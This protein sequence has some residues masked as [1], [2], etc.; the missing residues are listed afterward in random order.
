MLTVS[1]ASYESPI[2]WL[3]VSA[4]ERGVQG[5]RFTEH[6]G[7]PAGVGNEHLSCCLEQLAAYFA[8]K[9]HAF[10]RFSLAML[11]TEFQQRVWD[12]ALEIPFGR[13][14]TYAE[15]AEQLGGRKYARAVARAL[16]ANP[17]LLI[18]PCHRVIA[19]SGDIGGFSAG[20]WR[21]E[22]LLKFESAK[23]P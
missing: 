2:G 7:E 19:S 1:R 5:I 17:L 16:G 14:R 21:K 22:W 9:E 6:P 8:G 20:V 18:I 13:K 23:Q 10:S 15:L 4:V 11:G 3:E 12:A